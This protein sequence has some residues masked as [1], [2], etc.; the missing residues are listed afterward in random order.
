MENDLKEELNGRMRTAWA[1]FAAVREGPTDGP[2]YSYPSV[3]LDSPSSA[4]L[5]SGDRNVPSSQNGSQGTLKGRPPTRWGDVFATRMDQLRAQLDTAQGPRQCH[6]R[7]LRTSWMT[8]ARE[9][10]E[11]KRCWASTSNEDGPSKYPS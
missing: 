5:R 2:R 9:R 8:M 1:A 6:S 11:W 10:N 7:S 4:L 3:Q